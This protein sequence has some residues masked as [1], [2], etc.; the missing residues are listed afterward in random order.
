MPTAI[1]N[2]REMSVFMNEQCSATLWSIDFVRRKCQIG[3]IPIIK[4]DWYFA[5]RLGCI[6]EKGCQVAMCDGSNLLDRIDIADFVVR[7]HETKKRCSRLTGLLNRSQ[8][9]PS[10]RINRK[11]LQVGQSLFFEGMAGI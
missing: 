1:H 10:E 7:G 4:G 6:T 8:I 9:N 11:P 5:Y 2:W 3:D